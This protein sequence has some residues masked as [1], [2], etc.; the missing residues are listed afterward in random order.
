MAWPAVMPMPLR[1]G[2]RVALV[3]PAGAVRGERIDGAVSA[4]VSQGF[5]VIEGNA[6]RGCYKS[7]SAPAIERLADITAALYDPLIKAIFCARGG[8]G[9]IHL[10]PGLE[11]VLRDAT[12]KWLVGFSDISALHAAWL[13]AGV[14]S[15]HGPMARH[16]TELPSDNP[17]TVALFSILSG[18]GA[19][20][21]FVTNCADT[22][23]ITAPVV[24]GNMA[25][26]DGLVGTPWD[27]LSM[28]DGSLMMFEDINE[29]LYKIDRMFTRMLLAGIIGRAKA[30][31]LGYFSGIDDQSLI[32]DMIRSRLYDFGLSHIPIVD[33]LPVGHG[34]ANS[35]IPIGCPVTLKVSRG[36]AILHI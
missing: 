9:A 21:E 17:D 31:M 5:T 32:S 11:S 12:P 22:F 3:A 13:R 18:R 30:L 19:E 34:I 36:H 35:P 6:L 23:A 8:F 10:L 4:L 29:P 24:G 26:L 15:V 33:G 14:V 28:A 2:D 7:Y 27:E 1:S 25:V 20:Y 16:L